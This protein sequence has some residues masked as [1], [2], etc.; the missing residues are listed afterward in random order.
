ME[1]ATLL[2]SGKESDEEEQK[3]EKRLWRDA[4]LILGTT[5]VL[6]ADQNLMAPN[7]TAIAIDLGIPLCDRDWDLGGKIGL[8]F[9]SLVRLL[10]LLSVFLLTSFLGLSSFLLYY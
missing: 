4:A 8:A 5:G 10:P 9:S 6:F 2:G 3:R 7:L 1:S